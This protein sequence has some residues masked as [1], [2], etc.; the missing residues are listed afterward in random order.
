MR[1]LVKVTGAGRDSKN[2]YLHIKHFDTPNCSNDGC[3]RGQ[4]FTY[5]RID[6]SSD[7][8]DNGV[9]TALRLRGSVYPAA[10]LDK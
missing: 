7:C 2:T 5:Y 4:S 1:I 8:S 6:G 9:G 10:L 3:Y